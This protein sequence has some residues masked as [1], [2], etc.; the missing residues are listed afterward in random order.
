MNRRHCTECGSFDTERV[1]VEWFTDGVEEIRICHE[2][3]AQFT[4]KYHLFEQ[5]T[6][7]TDTTL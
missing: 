5:T 2:C 4:N 7:D 3:P 6:D 1:H